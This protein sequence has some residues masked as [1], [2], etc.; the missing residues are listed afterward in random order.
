MT[1][2]DQG[3]VSSVKNTCS[4]EVPLPAVRRGVG[5]NSY[6]KSTI[7]ESF[8]LLLCLISTCVVYYEGYEFGVFLFLI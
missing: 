1:S 5:S 8:L 6:L 3:L 7:Q 2:T 4:F